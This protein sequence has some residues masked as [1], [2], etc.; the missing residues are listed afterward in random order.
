MCLEAFDIGTGL[1]D[2]LLEYLCL[3]RVVPCVRRLVVADG[4][5]I[6]E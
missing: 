3:I 2:A 1:V 6:F 4:D 5:G